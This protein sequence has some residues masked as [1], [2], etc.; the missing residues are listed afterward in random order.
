DGIRDPLVT[1][2]QTCALPILPPAEF[3]PIAEETGLIVPMGEWVLR[4][5]CSQLAAWRRAGTVAPEV[6]MAVNVS[7]RQLSHPGLASA[8][9]EIGRAS[10][11]EG[12]GGGVGGGA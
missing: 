5:A 4:E 12:V 9:S 8:V 10:G 6:R 3:I 7:A 1:G 2:V 11:R